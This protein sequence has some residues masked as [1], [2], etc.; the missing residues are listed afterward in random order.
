MTIKTKLKHTKHAVCF[1][2]VSWP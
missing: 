2:R 1:Y